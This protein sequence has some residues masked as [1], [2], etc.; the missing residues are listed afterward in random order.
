MKHRLI[1]FRRVA[2][3][4]IA[5]VTAL[6]GLSVLG[7]STAA[8]ATPVTVT[9]TSIVASSAPNILPSG[10]NQTAGNLVVTLAAGYT[11]TAAD[12]F[13][14]TVKD[15]AAASTI[16]WDHNPTLTVVTGSGDNDLCAGADSS[17]CTVTGANTGVTNGFML[18]VNLT[19]PG[20]PS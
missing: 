14:I 10:T 12:S 2:V 4:C 13:T 7:L 1:R 17:G 8:S 19:G 11:T 20:R 3:A 5:G 9:G 16:T 18:T 15:S 6:T